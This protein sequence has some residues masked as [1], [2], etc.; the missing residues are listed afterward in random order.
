VGVVGRWPVESGSKLRRA[1]MHLVVAKKFDGQ[2]Q[3]GPEGTKSGRLAQDIR[4]V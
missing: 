3:C 1:L 4:A 2:L